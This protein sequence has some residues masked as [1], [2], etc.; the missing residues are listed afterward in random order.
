[1]LVDNVAGTT[2]DPVDSMVEVGGETWRSTVVVAL[3]T[4]VA[5]YLLFLYGLSIPLPHLF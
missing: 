5:F 2:R 4:T 1:M 3:A